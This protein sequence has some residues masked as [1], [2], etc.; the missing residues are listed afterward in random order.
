MNILYFLNA[1][2]G[3]GGII[4]ET[5]ESGN[6]VLHDDS[7]K[8]LSAG[9]GKMSLQVVS[10]W[11]LQK[12]RFVIAQEFW[13]YFLLFYRTESDNSRPRRT[14]EYHTLIL[15]DTPFHVSTL[16]FQ[17]LDQPEPDIKIAFTPVWL[18]DPHAISQA[19]ELSLPPTYPSLVRAADTFCAPSP[20]SLT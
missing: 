6:N 18:P 14:P 20:A 17:L 15:L 4:A 1:I 3:L 11:Y 12:K 13:H 16:F 10:S 7:R 2:D 5:F 19:D 9:R 8:Y